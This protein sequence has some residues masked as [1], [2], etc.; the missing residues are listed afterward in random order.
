[1]NE[2]SAFAIASGQGEAVIQEKV[3]DCRFFF[4]KDKK[5]FNEVYLQAT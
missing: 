1:M 3:C 5:F 2:K 4:L